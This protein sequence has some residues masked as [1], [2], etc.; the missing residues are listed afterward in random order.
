MAKLI[1]LSN[2]HGEDTIGALLGRKIR[3]LRPDLNIRAYPLVGKGDSYEE[4]DFDVLGPR[5]VMPSGGLTLHSGSMLRR[6]LCAGFLG[7]T[8]RQWRDLK[9]LE[10][11]ILL[12]VGDIYAQLQS[13]L[14]KTKCRFV[15]QALVS[16]FHGHG[17]PKGGSR[18]VFME[19]FTPLERL[20]MNRLAERVYVRD[21]KTKNL[22]RD[23]G[24]SKVKFLGNPI[25]DL[26]DGHSISCLTQ[27][28]FSVV[29]LP[30]SRDYAGLAL[31]VMLESFRKTRALIG[32][33]AWSGGKLPV[34]PGWRIESGNG[35]RGLKAV[36][37]NQDTEVWVFEDRFYDLLAG[38]QIV[39]GTAGTAHGIPIIAFPVPPYYTEL[40]LI[41]QQR[42]LGPALTI[43]RADPDEIARHLLSFRNS[44]SDRDKAGR[45]GCLRMGP[46]G[47]AKAIVRDIVARAVAKEVLS[48]K[49]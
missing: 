24:V 47:G 8:L 16:A 23:M 4:A 49:N 19:V 26:A 12:V 21:V 43:S 10:T 13:A 17:R 9:R 3:E 18:R 6:D 32:A 27:K 42:L 5:R 44:K 1:L 45:A 38:A 14:I 41:N 37:R 30:G 46:P 35:T 33:V 15:Y 48:P 34:F 31:G 39:L 29:L 22:L 20:L 11:D 2:G 7:L 28:G 40:F 36:L 25:I